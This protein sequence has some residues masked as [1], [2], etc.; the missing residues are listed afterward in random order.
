VAMNDISTIVIVGAGL[1]GA[2]AAEALRKEGFDG[3]VVL[4]GR[5]ARRPYI[6]PPLSKEY[7]RGE[8]ELDH[9]YVHPQGWY[10]EQRVDLEEG[11]DV[12]GI[13][14][15]ARAVELSTGRRI[16]FDRLL[17]A[18]GSEPR[19]LDVPGADLD[20]VRYLRTIDDSDGIRE[21]AKRASRVVVIGGGWIG[22]EVAASVR[23][24]GR[25][26][27][28]IVGGDA[29]LD[30]VLGPEVS[31]IYRRLHEEHGVGLVTNQRATA[32]HGR[33]GAAAVVETGDGQRI[34]GDLVVVGIG[35]APRTKL[36]KDAGL[37][38]GDGVLVDDRLGS[39]DPGIYA[40]GDIASAAHPR[41]GD[42][43]RIEHW[44]NARRQGRV[45]A[46]NMLGRDE[47]YARVP[48]FF[49]DQFDLSMEYAG[50]APSWDR[51]VFRGDPAGGSFIAFW[52]RD[53]RVVAG[54]NANVD[55]ANAKLSALVASGATVD[56][57]RLT[58]A[59][60]PLEELAPVS[61]AT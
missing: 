17:L 50:Y 54:M 27:V 1:T 35:A 59:D 56:E 6:R 3:K 52:L 2:K 30:K 24:L 21:D 57:G 36:A 28:L 22:A 15:S 46:L 16:G 37:K 39:S 9:V 40:A 11:A 60:V 8:E 29:P 32:I 14:R 23:Q 34:E 42:R 45:A 31:G 44:D 38:V 58:D 53:G 10:A 5:E 13:D 4:L 48:Y 18:T 49:S 55:K 47:P 25:D 51:V 19:R 61:S 12:T 33:G 26:V 7:L 41:F 43:V 20:G